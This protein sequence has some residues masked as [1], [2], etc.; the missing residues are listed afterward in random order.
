MHTVYTQ[1]CYA[2]FISMLD[3]YSSVDSTFLMTSVNLKHLSGI[4]LE[5]NARGGH[6]ETF[7]TLG[8]ASHVPI[9]SH[10]GGH[11]PSQG[12]GRA[13]FRGGEVPLLPPSKKTLPM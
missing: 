11:D 3:V 9:C 10:A 2:I 4:F 5:K 6:I 7:Y 13:T 1:I 12:G 8:G